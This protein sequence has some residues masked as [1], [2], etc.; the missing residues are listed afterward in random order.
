MFPELLYYMK[1]NIGK[2]KILITNIRKPELKIKFKL[3]D[4]IRTIHI[5]P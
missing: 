3:T 2:T 5:V 4:E 1:N